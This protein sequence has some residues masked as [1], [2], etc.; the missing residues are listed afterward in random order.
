MKKELINFKSADWYDGMVV[1]CRS[2]VVETQYRARMEVI[3]GKW[4]IGDRIVNDAGY[5]RS[6]HGSGV[7][8]EAFSKDIGLSVSDSYD[9]IKFRK[10]FDKVYDVLESFDKTVSWFKIRQKY[11]GKR[12]DDVGKPRTTYKIDE[13]ILA[14]ETWLDIS[15]RN[16]VNEEKWQKERDF[17]TNQFKK[18]LIKLKK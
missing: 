7:F 2:I 17:F 1:D 13:I 8:M 11:L 15:N 18:F 6:A 4:G 16:N 12:K 9:C 10:M 14:F 3:E 5:V